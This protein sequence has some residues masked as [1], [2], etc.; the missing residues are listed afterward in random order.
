MSVHTRKHHTE[1]TNA[2]I[3]I[4]HEGKCYRVHLKVIDKYC[5][6]VASKEMVQPSDLF[7]V[8]NKKYTKAGALLRGIR[9]RENLT[10]QDMAQKLQVTQSDISQM[11]TGARHIG[12]KVAKRIEQLFDVDYRTLME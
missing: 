10:Q 6:G 7:S 2:V 4:A 9:Y 12:R 1:S 8:I 5:V 3:N 11:E